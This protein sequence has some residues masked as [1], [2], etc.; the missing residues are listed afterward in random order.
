MKLKALRALRYAS[1]S[2]LKGA[3]FECKPGDVRLLVAAKIAEHYVEP[4]QIARKPF[5]KTLAD[6]VATFTPDPPIDAEPQEER[7]KRSYKRRDMTA[8]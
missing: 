5:A 4:A 6:E 8:E 2:V 3:V 7:V 1:K